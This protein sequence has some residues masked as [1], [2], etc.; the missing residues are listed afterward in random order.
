ML[1]DVTYDAY[2][3]NLLNNEHWLRTQIFKSF[4]IAASLRSDN[5][6]LLGSVS[7][8]VLNDHSS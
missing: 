1:N 4:I 5:Y 6:D 7:G 3:R 2:Q 8:S